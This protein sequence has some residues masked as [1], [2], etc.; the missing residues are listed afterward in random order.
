MCSFVY[1]VVVQVYYFACDDIQLSMYNLQ[2]IL[3]P[4][5]YLGFFVKN[6]LTLRVRFLFSPPR[7]LRSIPLIYM[8]ILM[9]VA[10]C[11]Y[12]CSFMVSFG[13]GKYQFS[14]FFQIVLPVLG[15]LNFH[16]NFRISK[17]A[18]W[19]FERDCTESVNQFGEYHHLNNIRSSD[20]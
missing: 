6:L 15:S 1:G 20:P 13:I 8:S 5:N 9:P 3:F 17:E 10:H 2:T 16:I 7:I 11:L 14:L 18:S 19:D 4:L 12:Y